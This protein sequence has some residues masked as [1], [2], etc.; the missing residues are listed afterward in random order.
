MSSMFR[1]ILCGPSKVDSDNLE[2]HK[3]VA[4]LVAFL[5]GYIRKKQ[6]MT[7]ARSLELDMTVR[8]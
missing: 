1:M 7:T 3:Y 4:K 5:V 6:T 2:H 8:F